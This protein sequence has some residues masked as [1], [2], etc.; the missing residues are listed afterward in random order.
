M[1]LKKR[2]A[3]YLKKRCNALQWIRYS[4]YFVLKIYDMEAY[5]DGK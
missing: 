3:M 1:H 5:S 2:D 4:K